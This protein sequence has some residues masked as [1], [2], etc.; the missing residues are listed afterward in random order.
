MV[1]RHPHGYPK[2]VTPE[3]TCPVGRE[4]D[5]AA[6]G[7]QTWLLIIDGSV[8]RGNADRG[9]HGSCALLRDDL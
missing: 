6:I 5:R 2:I 3:S 7:G 1:A 8:Q 9:D 4:E